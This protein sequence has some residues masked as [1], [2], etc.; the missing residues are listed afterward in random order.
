MPAHPPTVTEGTLNEEMVW[1]QLKTVYDPEIPINIVDLGLIY[2]CQ[3]TQL[4]Q[5]TRKIDIRMLMTAP[6]C[7]MGNVLRADVEKLSS[8]PS[9]KEVRLHVVLILHG[10]SAGCRKRAK[11]QL[12]M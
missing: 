8:L 6:G 11:L 9:G 10:I 4:E 7:G 3:I 2:S 12:G 1:T 5:G